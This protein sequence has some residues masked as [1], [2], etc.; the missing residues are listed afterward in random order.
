MES[1]KQNKK[2]LI[3]LNKE[4][5][6]VLFDW[7]CRFNQKTN[8]DSFEDQSEERILWDIEAILEKI[9]DDILDDKYNDILLEARKNIRD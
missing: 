8:S 9:S 2:F 1:R 4:E 7:V 5:A 3:E 6:I